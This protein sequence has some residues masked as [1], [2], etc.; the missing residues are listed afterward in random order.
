[1]FRTTRVIAIAAGLSAFA[2][3]A[4]AAPGKPLTDAD[5]AE[6]QNLAN[7]YAQP[8]MNDMNAAMALARTDT[9]KACTMIQGVEQRA[10]EL[11]GRVKALRD[12]LVAEGKTTD[13]V[14]KMATG[15]AQ[16]LS[17]SHDTAKSICS[18]SLARSGDAETDATVDKLQGL[19]ATLTNSMIAY[20]AA[21]NANDH[22]TACGHLRDADVAYRDLHV[23]LLDLRG[24]IPA[25]SPGYAQL[26]AM[27]DKISPVQNKLALLD[28]CPAT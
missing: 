7:T 10:V 14:D 21:E 16:I 2:L 4:H 8:I 9:P 12:R 19:I 1:M 27:L 23:M 13:G 5:K 3:G 26:D 24:Q 17:G 22:V 18:G 6:A 28:T 11:D 25:G 15:S 20:A